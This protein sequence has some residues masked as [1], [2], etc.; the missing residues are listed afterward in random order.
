MF[1]PV[2]EK[3]WRM[4]SRILIVDDEAD[5]AKLLQYRL[6]L[7]GYEVDVCSSGGQALDEIA[8]NDYALVLLDFFLPSLRGDT[9]CRQIRTDE[10]SKHLPIIIMTAFNN[11]PENFFTECGATDVLYKPFE[12]DDLAAKM[13]KYITPV[14]E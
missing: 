11:Y 6:E 7:K 8:R 10:H 5:I 2:P 9:V 1:L 14:E 4:G 3:E 12:V 13:Q